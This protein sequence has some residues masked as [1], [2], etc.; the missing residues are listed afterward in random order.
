MS[1]PVLRRGA[2]RMMLLSRSGGG[3]HAPPPFVRLPPPSKKLPSEVEL[4]WNDPVA[5]EITI[6]F[7]APHLSKMQALGMFAAAW[8]TFA[9][10]FGFIY[11]FVDP[12][13]KK[14]AIDRVMPFDNMHRE[15]GSY[16]RPG[17][18]PW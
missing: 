14:P 1:L 9:A 13:S 5:P 18:K 6:D 16:P 10:A 3:G 2:T 11:Y 8:G 17:T 12:P 15:L 7:D 4:L